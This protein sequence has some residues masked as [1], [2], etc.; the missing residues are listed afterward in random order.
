MS[1]A[2]SVRWGF[3]LLHSQHRGSAGDRTPPPKASQLLR[4]GQPQPPGDYR[5]DNGLKRDG[6]RE[7][8]SGHPVDD[9]ADIPIDDTVGDCRGKVEENEDERENLSLRH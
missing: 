6:N 5:H 1:T 8:R 4:R 2:E 9:L 7:Y 3:V